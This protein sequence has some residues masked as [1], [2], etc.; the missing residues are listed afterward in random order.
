MDKMNTEN[1]N[2]LERTERLIGNDAIEKLKNSTVAVF[3]LGGVGGYVC[4]ALARSGIGHLII[5]DND[6]IDITN[7]NRQIIAL[8]ST[9]GMLKT[10]AMEKRLKDIN[11][12]I[13]IIRH[14]LFFLPENSDEIRLDDCDYIVD[15]IDTVVAKVELAVIGQNI[16]VPVIS[17]MGT[18][19]KLDASKLEVTDIYKTSVCPLARAM[20]KKLKEKGIKQLKVVYSKEIPTAEVSGRAPASAAF[21]PPAAGLIIAGEVVKDMIKIRTIES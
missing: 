10:E 16:G 11:P 7:I 9:V 15:A 2:W 14:E 12:E 20:R 3:G 18:G 1:N 8:H 4:E 17:S 5:V 19:N 21:V 6:K 13:E